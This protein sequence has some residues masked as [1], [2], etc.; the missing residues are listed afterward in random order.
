[1]W[2]WIGTLGRAFPAREFYAKEKARMKRSAKLWADAAAAGK[3][4]KAEIREAG[5]KR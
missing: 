2:G 3:E 1:M 5:S 4:A